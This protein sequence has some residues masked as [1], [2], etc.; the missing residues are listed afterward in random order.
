MARIRYL[1]PEF[2]KDEDL[3]VLLYET[4]LFFAGLWGLAD[5]SGRLE[6]RPARLKAEIFPYDNIDPENM[7]QQLT[8]EG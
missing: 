3:A 7:L 2:F 6:D 5:K 4:R 8:R 1:K